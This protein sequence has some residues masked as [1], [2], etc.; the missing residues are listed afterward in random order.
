M[1]VFIHDVPQSQPFASSGLKSTCPMPASEFAGV[2]KSV[3]AST[4]RT[5]ATAYSD[6]ALT[7]VLRVC[8]S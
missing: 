3:W 4:I 1:P 2:A 8:A 7:H 6:R 5:A